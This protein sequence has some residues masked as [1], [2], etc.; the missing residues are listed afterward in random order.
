MSSS[1][2]SAEEDYDYEKEQEQEQ[3][4]G[5]EYKVVIYRNRIYAVRKE[6]RYNTSSYYVGTEY[7]TYIHKFGRGSFETTFS[8]DFENSEFT[9]YRMSNV[10]S[11]ADLF[12]DYM[13]T[14]VDISEKTDAE[15][16]AI[17]STL[18]AETIRKRLSD[19]PS[20]AERADREAQHRSNVLQSIQ[21]ALHEIPEKVYDAASKGVSHIDVEFSIREYNLT[22]FDRLPR[23][24]KVPCADGVERPR[25]TDYALYLLFETYGTPPAGTT[26]RDWIAERLSEKIHKLFPHFTV[27]TVVTHDASA[28]PTVRIV[29]A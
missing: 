3:E 18:L 19:V 7:Y 23:F 1:S 22:Q 11:S 29:F 28:F 20:Q 10:S 12:S 26:P 27:F 6:Y 4:H 21:T 24:E 16:N 14:V 2:D 8:I 9:A 15:I 25:F 13:E 17:H 5:R